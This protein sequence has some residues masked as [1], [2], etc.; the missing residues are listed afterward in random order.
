ME[1]IVL[2]QKVLSDKTDLILKSRLTH[3]ERSKMEEETNI[4]RNKLHIRSKRKM[5]LV[6]SATKY[7]PYAPSGNVRTGTHIV[8]TGKDI[9]HSTT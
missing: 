1:P 4:L 8:L 3:E 2:S 9:F 6:S 7:Q 5:R